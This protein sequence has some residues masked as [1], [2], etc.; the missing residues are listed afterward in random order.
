MYVGLCHKNARKLRQK[1]MAKTNK[2]LNKEDL[3]IEHAQIIKANDNKACLFVIF[4]SKKFNTSFDFKD[5]LN[6][7]GKQNWNFIL[8]VHTKL[9]EANYYS[10]I[11]SISEDIMYT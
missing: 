11:H 4:A 8:Y 3:F 6:L 7:K 1:C 9:I 5:N 10:H 2:C